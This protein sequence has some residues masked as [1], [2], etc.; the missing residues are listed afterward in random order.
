MAHKITNQINFSSLL[1]DTLFGVILFFSLDNLLNIKSP[2]HFIL[3]LASSLILIHWWLIFKSEDDIFKTEI[4]NSA[5][6]LIFRVIYL[7]FIEYNILMSQTFE[8]QQALYYLIGIF[9]VDL[10][11]GYLWKYIGKWETKDYRRIKAMNRELDGSIILNAFFITLFGL[12]GIINIAFHI[13]EL[14]FVLAYVGIYMIFVTA[15]FKYKL[16]DIK[17]Y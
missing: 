6:N 1:F 8:Y 5:I 13:N 7:I 10:V 12:L 17:V 11:W 3:Y 15:T 9:V 2:A 16:I 4:S 14:V